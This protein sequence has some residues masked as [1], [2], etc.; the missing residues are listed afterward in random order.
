MTQWSPHRIVYSLAT[1]GC[2]SWQPWAQLIM[3]ALQSSAADPPA[4]CACALPAGLVFTPLTQPYLHEFGED[5]SNSCPRRLYDKSMHSII[6]K[7]GQQVVILS[8]VSCGRGGAS[9]AV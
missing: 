9:P 6:Q 3:H 8:Q 4:G 7:P 1:R 5:W 2:C